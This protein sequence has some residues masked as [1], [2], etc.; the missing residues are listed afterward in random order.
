MSHRMGHKTLENK[1]QDLLKRIDHYGDSLKYHFIGGL[2][3]NKVM[4]LLQSLLNSFRGFNRLA[5]EIQNVVPIKHNPR[6]SYSSK[7]F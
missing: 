1:V 2:Q 7:C 3:R 4:I 6:H 5:E